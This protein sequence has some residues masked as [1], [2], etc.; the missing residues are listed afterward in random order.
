MSAML[1][2]FCELN[3]CAMLTP[4]ER[5]A[6]AAADAKTLRIIGHLDKF[7]GGVARRNFQ[8]AVAAYSHD[9]SDANRAALDLH[10]INWM[11]TEELNGK[12][13]RIIDVA[14]TLG[15]LRAVARGHPAPNI[16]RRAARALTTMAAQVRVQET[17]EHLDFSAPYRES[18]IVLSLT[19]SAALLWRAADQILAD[20][21]SWNGPS[22]TVVDCDWLLAIGQ[23]RRAD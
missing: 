1:L 4:E 13:R 2:R 21:W 22:H 16:V 15:A 3:H 19:N 20:G 23:N 12:Q 6:L 11:T 7:R 10:P 5:D 17:A 14:C 9:P 18:N 8:A